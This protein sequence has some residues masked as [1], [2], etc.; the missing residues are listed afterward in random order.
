MDLKL[1]QS[2]EVKQV[3]PV[4]ILRSQGVAYWLLRLEPLKPDWEDGKATRFPVVP[5]GNLEPRANLRK[6][7][8]IIDNESHNVYSYARHLVTTDFSIEYLG[9]I[10]PVWIEEINFEFAEEE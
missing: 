3:F 8:V 4:G 5:L 7:S 6:G 9:T 1:F 2:E 10:G